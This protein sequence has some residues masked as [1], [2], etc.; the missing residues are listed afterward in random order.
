MTITRT[1]HFEAQAGQEEA[2]YAFL[3]SIIGLVQGCPGCISCT[4]YR[5]VEQPAQLLIIE[6]WQ[7]VEAHQNAAQ[8]VPPE[9]IGE[10]LKLLAK[11]PAGMYYQR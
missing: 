2:L 5:G 4:L 3:Q 9:K 7:S 8:A 11:P 1:N 10:A 6:E